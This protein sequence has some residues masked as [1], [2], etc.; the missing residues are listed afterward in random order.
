VDTIQARGS[1]SVIGHILR[2]ALYTGMCDWL[3]DGGWSG[4][5][6]SNRFRRSALDITLI[7]LLVFGFGL[8]IASYVMRSIIMCLACILCETGVIAT[9]GIN[10]WIGVAALMVIIWCAISVLRWGIGER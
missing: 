3:F 2:Q 8:L 10:Q 9:I 6:E 7:L 1:Q 5:L 4:C